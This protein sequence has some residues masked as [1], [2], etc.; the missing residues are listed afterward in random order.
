MIDHKGAK[1]LASTVINVAF[2]DLDSKSHKHKKSARIFFEDPIFLVFFCDLAE[3]DSSSVYN[4][5]LK[6]K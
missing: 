1:S 4:R 3:I 2:K 5:Y 6:E